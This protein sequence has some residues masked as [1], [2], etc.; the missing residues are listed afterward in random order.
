MQR[1]CLEEL[2]TF[3][4]RQAWLEALRTAANWMVHFMTTTSRRSGQVELRK[5]GPRR[6]CYEWLVETIRNGTEFDKLINLF[7]QLEFD[8]QSMRILFLKG[9]DKTKDVYDLVYE[10]SVVE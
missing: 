9:Y 8:Q 6:E 4:M 1:G 7:D 10:I 5:L 3:M 2:R